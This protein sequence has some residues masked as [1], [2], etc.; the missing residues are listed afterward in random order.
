MTIQDLGSVGELIAAVATIA[1]LLYLSIQIRANTV[2]TRADARGRASSETQA[3]SALLGGNGEAAS[4]FT[5]GVRDYGA[6][7][8]VE[9]ARFQFLFA[10][11]G[12]STDSAY[13]TYRLGITDHDWI[14]TATSGF[15]RLVATPGGREF[16][17]LNRTNYSSE[18]QA[19]VEAQ[20]D[21]QLNTEAAAQ[22]GAAADSA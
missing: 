20:T 6:L 7:D 2:S 5:R 17:R 15:L 22:Q 16:W 14:E 11:L 12:T 10:M 13:S 3:F 8:P 19:F 9:Q 4:I 1:T 21:Q 18:F